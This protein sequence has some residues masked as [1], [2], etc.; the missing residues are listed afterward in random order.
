MFIFS[1]QT[2]WHGIDCLHSA[3]PPPQIQPPCPM[4]LNLGVYNIRY[5]CGFVLPHVIWA[6]KPGNYYLMLLMETNIIDVVYCSKLLGYNVVCSKATL[7]ADRVAQGML[8]VM[9][10]EK[11]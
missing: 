3:P 4:R 5:G 9:S 10:H 8:V 1:T 7:T 2:K 11:P 6:V